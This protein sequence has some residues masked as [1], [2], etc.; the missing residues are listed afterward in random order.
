VV[1]ALGC[2]QGIL[3]AAGKPL[4]SPAQARQYLRTTGSVQQDAPGRPKSQR[5]GNR[6]D[7]RQLINSLVP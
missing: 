5:I 3:K 1:G 4:L 6:P 7:L 2:L